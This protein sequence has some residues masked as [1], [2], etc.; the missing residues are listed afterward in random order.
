MDKVASK[1]KNYGEIVNTVISAGRVNCITFIDQGAV[2]IMSTIHDAANDLPC[3]RPICTRAN[4]S[5]HLAR[6]NPL[7]SE[8]EL[9]YPKISDDYNH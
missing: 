3:W 1:E 5:T 7:T 2:W 9:L 4:A 6:I 8:V